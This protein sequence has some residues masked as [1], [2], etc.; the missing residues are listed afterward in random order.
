MR[1]YPNLYADISALTQ[2]N[3][4]GVLREA[5]TRPEF[6]GRLLYGT[7]FPLINTLLVSPW[8]S[9]HLSLRQKWALSRAKNPWD[10]DVLTKQA[11]GV[12][13]E[14]FARPGRWFDK[15]E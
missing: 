14:T 9:F 7:D 5:V 4:P 12:P 10:E 3:K 6:S 11:L 13:A 15:I 1:E 8:Y 2:I